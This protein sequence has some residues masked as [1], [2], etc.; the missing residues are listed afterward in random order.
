M[1]QSAVK[2]QSSIG[3]EGFSKGVVSETSALI[4]RCCY[5]IITVERL[6]EKIT[7][8]HE[9]NYRCPKGC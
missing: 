2:A 8:I 9:S 1:S 3:Y 6:E 7:Y 5:T 4:C